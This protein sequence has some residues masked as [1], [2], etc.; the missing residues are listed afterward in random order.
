M[1]PIKFFGQFCSCQQILCIFDNFGIFIP[2]DDS[3]WIFFELHVP[4]LFELMM[5][6]CNPF[7][8][9]AAQR[10]SIFPSS[11]GW[12]RLLDP[13][14]IFFPALQLMNIIPAVWADDVF[15]RF[16]VLYSRLQAGNWIVCC[17]IQILENFKVGTI[18]HLY[19]QFSPVTSQTKRTRWRGIP[20]V[21]VWLK[22]R[23]QIRK[24]E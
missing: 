24:C 22:W 6:L 3:P 5:F 1:F 2:R 4:R 9:P 21:I 23:K 12:W 20:L 7:V 17:Q 15:K 11:L 19:F 18:W 16:R 8:L 13:I 10:M 14:W